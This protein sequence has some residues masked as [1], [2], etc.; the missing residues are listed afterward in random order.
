MTS[1]S[2]GYNPN[3]PTT[4]PTPE[5]Q[6]NERRISDYLSH[7]LG[8]GEA[9]I[10]Q[11]HLSSCSYC[12]S[13]LKSYISLDQQIKTLPNPPASPRVRAA[14]MRTI[15]AGEADRRSLK[16]VNASVVNAA[17]RLASSVAAIA[18]L[19]VF[20]GTMALMFS[21]R[22]LLSPPDTALAS[23]TAEAI[24]PASITPVLD[25]PMAEGTL[26]LEAL[27]TGT[28]LPAALLVQQVQA[29][30]ADSSTNLIFTS[31]DSIGVTHTVASRP[32]V[33][34]DAPVTLSPD[35]SKAVYS[36]QQAANLKLE[37]YDLAN[38][39]IVG[40]YQVGDPQPKVARYAV[41]YGALS[42]NGQ[43]LAFAAI[44]GGAWN[45]GIIDAASGKLLTS[46]PAPGTGLPVGIG[47][48]PPRFVGWGADGLLYTWMATEGGTI[49]VSG[50]SVDGKIARTVI[51]D[52]YFSADTPWMDQS[53]E[54]IFVAVSKD[55]AITQA[56]PNL[57]LM[58]YDVASGKTSPLV[59]SG[60]N[61]A[62]GGPYAE[63]SDGYS[64]FYTQSDD[65]GG[66]LEIHRAGLRSPIDTKVADIKSPS[67]ASNIAVIA[68]QVC[69]AILYYQTSSEDSKGNKH[70]QLVAQSLDGSAATLLPTQ[71][72][73]IGCTSTR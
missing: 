53:G 29:S 59:T 32:N 62:V 22:G 49:G 68:M 40:S 56:S 71:G 70:N 46:P 55:G 67:A 48:T 42:R 4:L 30:A 52:G 44:T 27:P 8:A 3:R 38:R 5:C 10:L 19:A 16:P 47:V 54:H 72:Q 35:Q 63:P 14:V 13:L 61:M 34:K 2:N 33:V 9:A 11:Q 1:K 58:K 23:P 26:S 69:G 37:V 45:S 15:A 18:L 51:G 24:V 36:T 20:A 41:P 50:S 6:T 66:N 31:V 64:L 7:T 39:Q 21:G 12:S 17:P 28:P 25:T 60:K 65:K 73:L 43:N 57:A